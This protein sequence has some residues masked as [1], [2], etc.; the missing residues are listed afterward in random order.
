MRPDRRYLSEGLVGAYLGLTFSGLRSAGAPTCGLQS[1]TNSGTAR[2]ADADVGSSTRLALLPGRDEDR[3]DRQ[4]EE[5]DFR[6]KFGRLLSGFQDGL[7]QPACKWIVNKLKNDGWWMMRMVAIDGPA[8]ESHLRAGTP[9]SSA[10]SCC[11][12]RAP[13][14][15]R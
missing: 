15:R 9:V 6:L 2:P 12:G 1:P 11:R 4:V 13:R 7:D 14:T 3:P 5:H 8:R 10:V